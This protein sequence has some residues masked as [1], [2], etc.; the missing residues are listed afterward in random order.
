M[1]KPENLKPEHEGLNAETESMYAEHEALNDE[2]KSLNS[3]AESL[4]QLWTWGDLGEGRLGHGIQYRQC[5]PT[6][7]QHQAKLCHKVPDNNI[8]PKP[9][10]FNPKPELFN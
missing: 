10:T 7:Y 6:P 5:S 2:A 8:R 9:A 3:E 4:K 1:M